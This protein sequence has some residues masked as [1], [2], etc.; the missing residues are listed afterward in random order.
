MGLSGLTFLIKLH[1][2]MG[3]AWHASFVN[4]A[5]PVSLASKKRLAEWLNQQ[6]CPRAKCYADAVDD[7]RGVVGADSD[8]C[9]HQLLASGARLNGVFTGTGGLQKVFDA[10]AGLINCFFY[11][12]AA[13]AMRRFA[14][15][16]AITRYFQPPDFPAVFPVQ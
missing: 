4:M 2:L 12:A 8:H 10:L 7:P 3:A 5:K 15:T 9:A 1:S 16:W 13:G 14:Q 6:G 11:L